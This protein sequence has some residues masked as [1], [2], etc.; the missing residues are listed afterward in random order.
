MP[1]HKRRQYLISRRFQIKYISLILLFMFGTAVI[2]GYMVYVT[3]W[4]MFGEKL[5]AVYPQ[6]LLLEVV[7]NVN[8]VLLLRL[9]FLS[10]LVILV[11]LILS[12]RIAGPIYRIREQLKKIRSGDHGHDIKLREKDELKDL[13]DEVNDLSRDLRRARDERLSTLRSLAGKL[14]ELEAAVITRDDDKEY[15][16]KHILAARE[17]VESAR[18]SG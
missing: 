16:L 5:A 12:H 8:M 11:G 10:P 17:D 4:V 2:T 7:K 14:D 15:L 3:T 18:Q 13:A 9:I 1:K 6:G